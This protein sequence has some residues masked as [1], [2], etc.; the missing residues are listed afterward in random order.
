MIIKHA[1]YAIDQLR[2]TLAAVR[3]GMRVLQPGV[4]RP[5]VV[6][7]HID[8]RSSRPGPEVTFPQ[9]R[10]WLCFAAKTFGRG[11]ARAFWSTKPRG[12]PSG[13]PPYVFE[14]GLAFV[15][16]HQ[17]HRWCDRGM[18]NQQQPLCHRCYG[19]RLSAGSICQAMVRPTSR[20]TNNA[21]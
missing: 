17:C 10:N 13:Q 4:Q 2:P 7:R 8:Q 16:E 1:A 20:E 12:N 19:R 14:V 3:A 6:K 21:T 5:R 18:G 15:A 9:L 11:L